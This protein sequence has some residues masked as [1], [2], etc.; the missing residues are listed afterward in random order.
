ML[1]PMVMMMVIGSLL[2][3]TVSLGAPASE[4]VVPDIATFDRGFRA[5]QD[6]FNR[7]KY[8]D[9]ARVWAET[10]KLLPE[11]TENKENR[12]AIYGYIAD[13]YD[14]A[15]MG[16]GGDA[17]AREAL[18]VLNSYA[19]SFTTAYPAETLPENIARS[20][21]Q[22]RIRLAEREKDQKQP[23][24]ETKAS[25]EREAQPRSVPKEDIPSPQVVRLSRPW[26]RLAVGGGTAVAGGTAMLGMFIT[27]LV[28]AKVAESKFEDRQ[29]NCDPN[30]LA[31]NCA[32]TYSEG[33]R[34][35]AIAV[36]G[37]VAAPL[38]LGTGISM[39]VL[40]VRRKNNNSAI[41]PIVNLTTA[42]L[43]WEQRF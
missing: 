4:Q 10:A 26:K 2:R 13:A 20:R 29:N 21:E 25:A 39:L 14:R 38:L 16:G 17:V 12:Q 19:R 1:R 7:R 3:P 24:A 5:G 22:L 41:A 11:A 27:G 40:A 31:G 6:E 15:L 36:A 35:N 33:K 43:V 28:G 37:L 34:S 8:L 30:N 32:D 23:D 18:R 9:A 42:G